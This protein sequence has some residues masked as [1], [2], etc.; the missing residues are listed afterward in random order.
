VVS[1]PGLLT[2]QVGS[3]LTLRA[4]VSGPQN[5][6]NFSWWYFGG[7]AL[8]SASNLT[9]SVIPQ[10]TNDLVL[11]NLVAEQFG[12]YTFGLSNHLGV[13]ASYVVRV[14]AASLDSD[15]D[16]MPD[17]WE[18]AH[19]LDPNEAADASGD[20]DADGLQ[21]REEYVV[22]TDPQD[23]GSTLRLLVLEPGAQPENGLAFEF[24]AQA[25][26]AYRVE[27][28]EGLGL[29]GWSHWLSVPARSSNWVMAVTNGLPASQPYR[30]YRVVVPAP[31]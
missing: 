4:V 13:T 31:Q 23:A 26:R 1:V 7:T 15:G 18:L 30:F 12:D 6:T 10:F 17:D 14:E 3:N 20:A 19:G 11:S 29:E 8:Q 27:Y 28:R 21:N 5:F 9:T 2:A 16:G 25:N 24:E 22:G